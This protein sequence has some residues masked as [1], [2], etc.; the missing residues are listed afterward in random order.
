MRHQWEEI[1]KERLSTILDGLLGM[2][3]GLSAY[4]LTGFGIK[5]IQDIINHLFILQ[6]FSSNLRS[7]LL[8]LNL[9]TFIRFCFIIF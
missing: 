2:A 3:L 7:L 8:S 4:S 1:L 9:N 6:F 5:D